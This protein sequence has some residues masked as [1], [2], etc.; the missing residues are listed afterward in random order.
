MN[1][2]SLAFTLVALSYLLGEADY[3]VHQLNLPCPSLLQRTNLAEARVVGGKERFLAYV[4]TTNY[5]FAF[6]ED[7]FLHTLAKRRPPDADAHIPEYHK[8]LAQQY[9]ELDTNG[10]HQLATQWLAAVG[11]DVQRLEEMYA[12]QVTFPK[13]DKAVKVVH[14]SRAEKTRVVPR[15]WITWGKFGSPGLDPGAPY[16]AQVELIGPTK[17]LAELAVCVRSLS[18]RPPIAVPGEG[19][20]M[21]LPN[22]AFTNLWAHRELS[23]TNVFGVLR[24][25]AAYQAVMLRHMLAEANWAIQQLRLPAERQL[26]LADVTNSC[27]VPPRFGFR[28]SIVAK[29]SYFEFDEQGKLVYLLIP[30][31]SSIGK[32]SNREFY[33]EMSHRPMLVDSNSV[34]ELATNWLKSLRI[35]LDG[36][37]RLGEPSI[38]RYKYAR[39]KPSHLWWLSWH[40]PRTRKQVLWVEVDGT[41]KHPDRIKLSFPEFALHPGIAIAN[42]AELMDIPDKVPQ[43]HPLMAHLNVTD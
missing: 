41:T 27:V 14:G 11:V 29:G 15:F 28:G 9:S 12:H 18:S 42:A 30:S 6:H 3:H 4:T 21:S 33:E 36:L 32:P 23:P 25:S 2:P 40:E 19:V 43:R 17:E 13:L 1:P 39:G 16:A 34:V 24:T 22:E 20:L 7:G 35:D 38:Q 10:A 26:V 31:P 8:F 5:S 37:S